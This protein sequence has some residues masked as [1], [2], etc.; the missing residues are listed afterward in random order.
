MTRDLQLT[1]C[2]ICINRQFAPDKG[3]ICRLINKKADFKDDCKSYKVDNSEF[4]R[5]CLEKIRQ[6]G[7]DEKK[8]LLNH[9]K[10]EFKNEPPDKYELTRLIEFVKPRAQN[11]LSDFYSFKKS[12]TKYG[13]AISLPIILTIILLID[14]SKKDSDELIYGLFGLTLILSFAGL[15]L[16]DFFKNTNEFTVSE[17][18]IKKNGQII[19]WKIVLA[20]LIRRPP[21]K[22]NDKYLVLSVA[23]KEDIEIKLNGIEGMPEQVGNVIELYKARYKALNKISN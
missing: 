3:V 17:Q 22:T 21:T 9:L 8:T 5:I 4:E 18:G 2:L 12:L 10:N 14:I 16:W 23:T 1:F 6:Y 20:T 11:E 13:L 19:P 7:L 15:V